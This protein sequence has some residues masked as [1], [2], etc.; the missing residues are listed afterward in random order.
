MLKQSNMPASTFWK[1]ALQAANYIRNRLPSLARKDHKSPFEVFTGNESDLTNI[2]PF[3]CIFYDH[4]ADK[5]RD[6]KF[7]DKGIKCCLVGYHSDHMFK[8]YNPRNGTVKLPFDVRFLEDRYFLKSVYLDP[9]DHEYN[10][11]NTIIPN[12]Q[13]FRESQL[14][15]LIQRTVMPILPEITTPPVHDDTVPCKISCTTVKIKIILRFFF[16]KYTFA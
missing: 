14:S 7:F 2:R 5:Q 12:C 3:G 13:S 9:I 4:L 15:L 11:P 6:G 16:S 10:I 1:H 8:V